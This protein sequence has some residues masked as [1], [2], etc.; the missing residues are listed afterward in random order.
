[1]RRRLRVEHI[2]L[3]G[4][5]AALARGQK[6]TIALAGAFERDEPGQG[7]K[8]RQAR[9]LRGCRVGKVGQEGRYCAAP[10][11]HG[12]ITSFMPVNSPVS[13]SRTMHD[14]LAKPSGETWLATSTIG[15]LAAIAFLVASGNSRLTRIGPTP[16]TSMRGWW[17]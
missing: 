6:R 8:H 17:K 3:E 12:D 7:H 4:G 5:N 2:G 10:P 14:G 15:S 1:F 11:A 13:G 16:E 9:L